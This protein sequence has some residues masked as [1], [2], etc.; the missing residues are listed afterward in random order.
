VENRRAPRDSDKPTQSEPDNEEHTAGTP[1]QASAKPRYRQSEAA[2]AAHW[3]LRSRLDPRIC[4]DVSLR[5]LAAQIRGSHLLD[6]H[7]WTW[8]DLADQL[9]G[10][11]EYAHLPHYIRN[12]R[13][14]IRA[15]LTRANPILSP[16][17][18]RIIHDIERHSPTLRRRRQAEAE[19]ARRADIAQRRAVINACDL[20]DEQGWLHVPADTPTVRCNHDPT[21]GGW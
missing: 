13:A 7:E 12:C 10:Y 6:R 1:S 18:L 14:W 9:H 15:R 11:P 17:K 2:R 21:T 20:C 5:W 19:Q 3:L 4:D 16:G 8:D